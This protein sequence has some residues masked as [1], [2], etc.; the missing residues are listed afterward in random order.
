MRGDVHPLAE[1]FTAAELSKITYQKSGRMQPDLIVFTTLGF[2]V[3]GGLVLNNISES[4]EAWGKAEWMGIAYGAGVG[5]VLGTGIS[6]Y[7]P[8][9]STIECKPPGSR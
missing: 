3:L 9:T 6:L 7:T 5:L 8:S 1:S 2:A 4:E